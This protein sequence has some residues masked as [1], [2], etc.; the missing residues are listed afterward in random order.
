MKY[1]R[2]TLL[3]WWNNTSINPLTK[4]SIKFKSTKYKEYLKHT[5]KYNVIND[6]YHDYHGNLIDPIM[7]MDFETKSNLYKFK[8]CWDPLNGS[9]IGNDPRGPLYFDPDILIHYFYINRLKYLWHP[10]NNNHTERFGDGLGNGPDFY[11]KGRGVNYHWYLFRLPL[12]DAYC[13]KNKIG[14]QTTLGPILDFKEIVKIYK[15]AC[16][17][18]KSYLEK[19]GKKRP[20]LLKIYELYHESIKKPDFNN[21]N[22]LNIPKELIIENFNVLNIN[23][24]NKLRYL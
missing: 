24:V 8:Y 1:S 11:I 14:Q 2:E 16:K 18:K 21:I 19:F 12:F 17:R 22:F 3:K 6:E 15:L 4:R 10:P 5:L 13:D 23:A 9:I 7:K 20:N